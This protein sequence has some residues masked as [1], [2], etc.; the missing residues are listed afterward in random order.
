[1][2]DVDVTLCFFT[3]L[4]HYRL[5]D[6]LQDKLLARH[7]TLLL[8]RQQDLLSS[9][10]RDTCKAYIDSIRDDAMISFA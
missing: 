5:S 6:S 1:M 4:D 10:S 8:L 2:A 9:Q 7:V 3:N